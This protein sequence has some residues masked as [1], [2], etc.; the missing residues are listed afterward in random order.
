VACVNHIGYV[1]QK[2]QGH[3]INFNNMHLHIYVLNGYGHFQIEGKTTSFKAPTLLV[4]HPKDQGYFEV[5]SPEGWEEYWVGYNPLNFTEM[6]EKGLMPRQSQVFPISRPDLIRVWLQQAFALGKETTTFGVADTIDRLCEL[7]AAGAMSQRTESI[8]KPIQ[9][10]IDR[11]HNTIEQLPSATIDI[12][13]LAHSLGLSRS[14]FLLHWNRI[15]GEP[16]KRYADR[17]RLTQGCEMLIESKLAIKAIATQLGFADPLHFSR[18]FRQI[19]GQSPLDYR[20][21]HSL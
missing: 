3:R 20:K 7:A 16:P 12:G 18:R 6:G 14:N 5:E 21:N 11:V 4:C 9:L 13:D 8:E 15:V 2:K 19:V 1:P 17:L 10:A